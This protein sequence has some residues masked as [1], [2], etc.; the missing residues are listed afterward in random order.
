MREPQER[1][2]LKIASDS[3]LIF[4]ILNM[5][6]KLVVI[7]FPC[8]FLSFSKIYGISIENVKLCYSILFL[9]K[10]LQLLSYCL[11]GVKVRNMK[12]DFNTGSTWR[13]FGQ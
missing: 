8:N 7:F 1:F 13:R 2:S 11:I 4:K 10:P 9:K 3:F 5:D 12:M 6:L